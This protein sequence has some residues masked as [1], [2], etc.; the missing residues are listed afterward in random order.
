M[1]LQ[2]KSLNEIANEAIADI[3]RFT[4]FITPLAAKWAP[5]KADLERIEKEATP[6]LKAKINAEIRK[7]AT[8]VQS[9]DPSMNADNGPYL[10]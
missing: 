6:E 4:A 7:F 3:V 1:T 2:P 10:T 8:V 5:R 9:L